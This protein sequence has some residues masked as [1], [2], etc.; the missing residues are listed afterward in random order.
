MIQGYGLTESTSLISVNHPFKLGRKSIGKILPGREMKLDESGE[1]LVRGENIA[2]GYWHGKQLVPV[3]GGTAVSPL[4]LTLTYL[5]HTIGELCLSPVGLS[6][7]TKLA[8]QRIAA[9]PALGFPALGVRVR[10]TMV[11]G[12]HVA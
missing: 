8:P 3:A 5:L 4:W 11:H 10:G 6:A 12:P 1:I 7:M 2:Q 9:P